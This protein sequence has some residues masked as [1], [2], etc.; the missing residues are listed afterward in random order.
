MEASNTSNSRHDFGF[1]GG[2]LLHTMGSA[3]FVSYAYHDHVDP[4]HVNW[5]K[6]STATGRACSYNRSKEYHRFFLE[7]IMAMDYLNRNKIGLTPQQVIVLA[8]ELLSRKWRGRFTA[9]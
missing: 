3:W 2:E 9:A 7:K 6:I 4:S 8:K 5:Q 1:D